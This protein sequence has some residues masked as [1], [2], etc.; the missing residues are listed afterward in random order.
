VTVFF[1]VDAV[2]QDVTAVLGRVCGVD[3]DVDVDESQ[4]VVVA[5]YNAL[6]ELACQILIAVIVGHLG[7]FVR[8]GV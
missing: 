4:F 2:G 7:V 1:V 8:G 5:L 6:D 3:V